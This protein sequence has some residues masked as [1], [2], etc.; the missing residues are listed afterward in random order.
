[1]IDMNTKI[2]ESISGLIEADVINKIIT[3]NYSVFANQ[4]VTICILTFDDG[5]IVG[6][7]YYSLGNMLDVN[8]AIER[9]NAKQN[10]IENYN[11]RILIND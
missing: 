3:Q 8:N 4:C 9:M 11:N 10:A 1:M 7:S 5:Y 6:S 2:D